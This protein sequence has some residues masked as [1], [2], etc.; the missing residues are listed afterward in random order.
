MKTGKRQKT[1]TTVQFE[2]VFEHF[3]NFLQFFLIFWLT[4]EVHKRPKSGLKNLLLF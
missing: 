4:G 3:K 2:P 1:P